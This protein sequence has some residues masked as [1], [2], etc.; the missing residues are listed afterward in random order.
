VVAS[1]VTGETQITIP[2]SGGSGY[3]TVLDE[4]VSVSTTRNT[5]NFIGAGVT[6]TDNGSRTEVTIPGI[7]Y[8]TIALSDPNVLLVAPRTNYFSLPTAWRITAVNGKLLT[9]A[10]AASFELKKNGTT[11][12]SAP[13]SMGTATDVVGTLAVSPTLI[14]ANDQIRGEV[15]SASG[16]NAVGAQIVITYT[17]P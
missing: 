1:D 11:I 14:A 13:I 15:V 17:I 7:R 8:V 10:T 4:G 9:A 6:A 2:G 16:P 12:L 5:I 3:T